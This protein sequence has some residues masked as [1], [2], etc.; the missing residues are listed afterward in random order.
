MESHN[1]DISEGN[2][3]IYGKWH[4]F[5]GKAHVHGD[6]WLHSK[7]TMHILNSKIYILHQPKSASTWIRESLEVEIFICTANSKHKKKNDIQ[8]L[9]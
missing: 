3:Y 2:I 5:G 4:P 6:F 1:N 7:I 9:K 8:F